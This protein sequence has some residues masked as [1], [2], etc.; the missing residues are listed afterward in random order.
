MMLLLP[1]FG[2]AYASPWTAFLVNS[3]KQFEM[4][5]SWQARHDG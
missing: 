4:G 5:Y 1:C 3:A 2:A